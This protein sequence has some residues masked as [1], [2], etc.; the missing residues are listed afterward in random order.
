MISD[1]DKEVKIPMLFIPQVEQ[2]KTC[3]Q[4]IQREYAIYI[5]IPVCEK[6]CHFCSI[7]VTKFTNEAALNNYLD[8]LLFEMTLKK[9]I[10]QDSI[11]K[12]IHIGGGTPSVLSA[13]QIK[14]LFDGIT[15]QCGEELPEIVFEAN[16]SSLTKEKIDVLANYH[17][18]TLNIG[19]QTFNP[20]RLREM[21]RFDDVT[22]ILDCLRYALKT[23]LH[24]GIDL[25]VGLPNTN[26]VDILNDLNQVKQ[27]G[28][29][30]VF[31]YPYRLEQN[32]F[33]YN[34]N[35]GRMYLSQTEI[36]KYMEYAEREM[37]N[38]GY[39]AKTIYYWTREDKPLY[40]YTA[41]QIIGGEWIGIGAGAYTYLGQSVT[42]NELVELNYLGHSWWDDKK[43]ILKQNVTSQLIWDMSFMI[44]EGVFD[45]KRIIHKYGKIA[46]RYIQ[47]LIKKLD[48]YGYCRANNKMCLSIKGKVLLDDVEKV[49][50]EVLLN[51]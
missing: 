48:E 1:T 44:K 11:L 41:H 2:S 50:R 6:K 21:N 23:K 15:N 17:N 7:P 18:I 46:E 33:F 38:A 27:L 49:I 8:A 34:H 40:M 13:T 12:G 16:P 36:V 32:S 5:H 9:N 30:N 3:E 43:Q 20:Q 31:I 22:R 37:Q 39:N 47:I 19:I 51:E 26:V 4:I 14:R 29:K 45:T 42:H 35:S 25:I 10:L 24:I 28:I